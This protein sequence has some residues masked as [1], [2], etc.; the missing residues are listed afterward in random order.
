MGLEIIN[1]KTGDAAIEDDIEVLEKLLKIIRRRRDRLQI[2]HFVLARARKISHPKAIIPPERLARII[3]PDPDA[4]I[5]GRSGEDIIRRIE[6]SRRYHAQRMEKNEEVRPTTLAMDWMETVASALDLR[7]NDL[8]PLVKAEALTIT[9][10]SALKFMCRNSAPAKS[11]RRAGVMTTLLK[12]L[13]H[14]IKFL[15][16]AAPSRLNACAKRRAG[17]QYAEKP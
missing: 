5:A 4:M 14:R 7:T 11:S 17:R 16:L 6:R 12:T 2:T 3:P 9:P 1:G 13:V 10:G 8:K 15:L